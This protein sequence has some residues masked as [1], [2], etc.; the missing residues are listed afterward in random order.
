M[1]EQKRVAV[2]WDNSKESEYC[3]EHAIQLATVT[4]NSIL[5]LN[6]LYEKRG[7]FGRVIVSESQLSEEKTKLEKKAKEITDKYHVPT[8]ALVKKGDFIK[9]LITEITSDK[10]INLLVL[11]FMYKYGKKV[12]KG[13]VLFNTIRKTIIP[14]ITVKNP[15]KHK[16]YKELVLPLDHDR[17]Y[18]E[19]IAWIVFLAR[20]YQCNVNILKPYIKDEFMRK[21]MNNNVF[22]SRK[23]L[24]KQNIVYGIKTAKK[25]QPFKSEI[26]RFVELIDANMVVMMAKQF[27]KW[28]GD[29]ANMDIKAPVLIVPPRADI[30]K[31]GAL[32]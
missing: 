5:L 20:Y 11:P 25:T 12:F 28:V 14:Y 10:R 31:Y 26:F 18:K 22:F 8:T 29:D 30:I 13:R 9:N 27:N 32:A 15:P 16:Y 7:I 21:D 1:N 19:T 17:K 6:L 23:M 4:G 24:D 2:L 3:L